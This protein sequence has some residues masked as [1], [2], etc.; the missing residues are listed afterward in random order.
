MT[1]YDRI[2]ESTAIV[3]SRLGGRAPAVGLVLGS[4]LGAFADTLVDAVRLP[5]EDLPHFAVSRVPGHAGRLVVGC[6]RGVTVAAMQ[7]R[8]HFYE[9]HGLDVV[10]FPIRVLLALGVR[11][12]VITN[13]AGGINQALS[14]GEL[15]LI[16]DHLNLFPEGP[17]RGENDDRL[18]TRFPDMTRA[19]APEL[20]D[21]ARRAGKRAGLDLREGVYAGLPGPSYETPAEIRMLRTMGADLCG[22]ST[23]PEV[24]V[25]NH[26]GARVLGISCV[27]NLAAGITGAPLSHAEV[28]ETA[29]KA[30]ASF[31]KL[32][33]EILVELGK[34][35]QG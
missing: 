17:L 3:R 22:M 4:G 9:G 8:V 33:E 19:Y 28:T 11:T 35:G 1:L 13:A 10:T 23:V 7:G 12:F 14:P 20:R 32:L 5:Y 6:V 30:H 25:A 24:I 16:S 29:A 34:E 2:Q 26:Q 27:T 15:V 31:V 18:G 21:L